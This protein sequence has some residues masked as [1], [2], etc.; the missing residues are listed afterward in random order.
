MVNFFLISQL[1]YLSQAFNVTLITGETDRHV[2]LNTDKISDQIKVININMQRKISIFSDMT[3]FINLVKIFY[4]YK[5]DIVHSVSPKSG[6]LAQLAAFVS[7]I[8]IRI[9]TFTGQV[10]SS[11]TGVWRYVLKFIDSLIV[12]VSTTILVDSYSQRSFLMSEYILNH[13]NSKVLLNGSISGINDQKFS[14]SLDTYQSFRSKL[15][16]NNDSTIILFI[17]RLSIDKGVIDLL[18]AFKIVSVKLKNCYLV[19]VGP[20]ED[21]IV[22]N[23]IN[24]KDCESQI[25]YFDY[26]DK[27]E[28]FMKASD[29][30]CLPSF[31]E[32]FGNVVLEAALCGV[33]AIVSEIYGL[34]DVVEKDVTATTFL[35]GNIDDLSIALF[36]ILNN[37]AMRLEM[38]KQAHRRAKYLFSSKSINKELG[39]FYQRLLSLDT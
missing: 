4:K 9:H 26:T 7:G 14:A 38:G 33:P 30:L 35:P 32:G 23:Y 36:N 21:N 24:K 5:F 8:K 17:G 22:E 27:P 37:Q 29:V 11:K 28:Y 39:Q 2:A 19:L 13:D 34:K 1:N 31:R 3:A 12:R 18:E 16:L 20:D 15:N 10:W 6:L 25:L